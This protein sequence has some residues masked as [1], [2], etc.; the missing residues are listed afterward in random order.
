MYL[1]NCKFC[2]FQTLLKPR[3]RVEKKRHIKQ[4]AT[5]FKHAKSMTHNGGM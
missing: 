4:S 2:K 1:V 3:H 5:H